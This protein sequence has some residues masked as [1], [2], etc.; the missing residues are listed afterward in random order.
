VLFPRIRRRP[1]TGTTAHDDC[2]A[3]DQRGEPGVSGFFLAK[4]LRAERGVVTQIFTSWNQMASWL[5]QLQGL[6]GAASSSGQEFT[7]H[8]R[9]SGRRILSR[10]SH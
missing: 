4:P 5:S 3:D 7:N 10:H 6:Q 2:T 8:F 9:L 1:N